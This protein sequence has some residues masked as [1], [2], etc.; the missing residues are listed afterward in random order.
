MNAAAE[1]HL[2]GL[3]TWSVPKGGMFLW[4]KVEGVEDT[5]DMIMDKGLRKNIMLVPGRVF[6]PENVDP[7]ARVCSP[8]LRASYSIAPVDQFDEAMAR[9]ADL[10]RGEQEKNNNNN[11]NRMINNKVEDSKNEDKIR[12][13]SRMLMSKVN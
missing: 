9:L 1:K 7:T 4:I 6:M 10:I 5:W 2:T 3:A 13:A 11:N 12:P 8:Y